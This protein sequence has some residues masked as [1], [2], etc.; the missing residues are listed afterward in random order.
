MD[1]VDAIAEALAGSGVAAVAIL[2]LHAYANPEHEAAAAARLRERLPGVAVTASHEVSRQWREYERSNTAVLSAYVQPI[3]AHYLAN[4]DR[5]LAD[6][7]LVCPSYCMQS[8]GGLAKFA[9]AEA[10]PLALVE[11]GPAGGVAGAVRVGEAL[12]EPDI[13]Y[14]DVGGT[15]AKC[16]LVRDGRP[17]LKSDYKLEW[18]RLE[19]GL[20]GAGAGRRHRRDRRG[21]RV[22]RADRC[23]PAPSASGRRARAP[24][25][26]RPATTAA[27]TSRP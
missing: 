21:R 7:G 10:A 18:T 16:S 5:A 17:V 1:E 12:G 27:A 11:S 15:T 2:F 13:L 20:S 19:A 26:G 3:M 22:D 23:R 25:P 24:I 6:E 8:N 9:A 14:L 4:L